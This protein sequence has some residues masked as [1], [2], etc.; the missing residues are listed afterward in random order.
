MDRIDAMRVLVAAADEGSLAAAG[1]RLGK[2]PATVSRAITFLETHVGV[3]LLHRNTRAMKLSE[4]GEKYVSACRRMLLD[5]DE[6]DRIA[7][8]ERSS[9]RG[10][11]TISAPVAA[12]ESIL[13]P[14]IATYLD[15]FPDMAVRLCLQ[16]Q[17]SNLVDEG[18]DLA[19]RIAHL[20]D[21]TL[22]AHRVGEVRRVVAAAPRY[23]DAHPVI[24]TPA[25]LA[26]HAIVAMTHFG[27]RNWTFPPSPGSST[28]RT[29]AF[30]PRIVVNSIR[31]AVTSAV[32]AHGVTR[33]FSY[34]IA[35][36]VKEGS[37][38]IVLAGFE[39]EPLPVCLIAPYGRTDVPKVRTF[40]DLALP[41]LR[42]R[43]MPTAEPPPAP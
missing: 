26:S 14:I 39:H 6:A 23:L 11:L 33:M 10:T 13:Q 35:D 4:P 41:L 15:R 38:R 43:F 1:R 34:H 7:A 24:R 18:I 16:D 20:P 22:I 9:P 31:A 27:T 12:G 40:I 42:Q 3:E 37:L 17:P 2:S 30:T 25:D 28:A 5:L 32:A 8:G 36:Q 29:I 21:S 19:L